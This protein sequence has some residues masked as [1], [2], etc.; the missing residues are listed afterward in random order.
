[1]ALKKQSLQKLCNS[2]F[3]FDPSTYLERLHRLNSRQP[4]FTL[5]LW[6]TWIAFTQ[7]KS[8]Y[9]PELKLFCV[10]IKTNRPWILPAMIRS[11]E[12]DT[13]Q[14]WECRLTSPKQHDQQEWGSKD[15]TVL[16]ITTIMWQKDG[17]EKECCWESRPLLFSCYK[18]GRT[19][20]LTSFPQDLH[21][22][23]LHRSSLITHLCVILSV[24]LVR[25]H[26]TLW[27]RTA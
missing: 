25:S 19:E 9:S 7:C 5:S 8:F 2:G 16:P 22:S 13:L 4:P 6:R 24:R 17:F 12:R 1:M 26:V 21:R 14:T 23:S 15:F 20:L 10:Q 3:Q 18:K 11:R 27:C